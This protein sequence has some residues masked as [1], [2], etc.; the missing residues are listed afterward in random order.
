MHAPARTVGISLA[1]GSTQLIGR[2]STPQKHYSGPL[3]DSR[4]WAHYNP[5]FGD[6]VVTTPPKSGTTWVQAILALLISG[7]PLV[8]AN[9]SVNSPWFDNKLDDID[10]VVTRLEAQTSQRHVKTHTPFDG[11]PIWPELRYIAVYRHPIDVHFSSRKHV[12]N[13]RP[14]SAEEMGIDEASFPKDPRESF[15][16]FLEGEN[17]DHA[18]LETVAD[19]YKSALSQVPGDNILLLHYADMTADLMSNVRTIAAHVGISHPPDVMER[20]VEAATFR[21]MKANADRFAP[22]AGRDVWKNDS[23]FFDSAT[24]NKWEGVLTSDDMAAYDKAISQLLDRD[25]RFWLEWG[26]K[27]S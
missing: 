10:E 3:T 6:I 7:D 5:R 20:L 14:E 24:S 4:R 23:A 26:S 19:H 11:I 22:A 13:Y 2:P 18:S 15:R 17:T 1:A 12:A 9:P 27:E 16:V 8:E 21:S 25:E